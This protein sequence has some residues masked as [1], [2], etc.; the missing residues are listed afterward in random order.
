[1]P[2]SYLPNSKVP[3]LDNR[4]KEHISLELSYSCRFWTVH[5]CN[6]PF[7]VSVANLIRKLFSG[8][9]L[10]FWFEVLSLLGSI[11]TCAAS[12]SS[13]IKWIMVSQPALRII[14]FL[15]CTSL[16]K[17]IRELWMMQQ[18]HKGFFVCSVALFRLAPLI[19][20]CPHYHFHPRVQLFRR[21]LRT[22]FVVLQR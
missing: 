5:V 19:C 12:L 6:M 13:L 4:I 7:N 18:M 15:M 10:L 3:D 2:S 16:K 21:R 14:H 17:S 1:M 11:N 20:T 9:E 8:K 22:S